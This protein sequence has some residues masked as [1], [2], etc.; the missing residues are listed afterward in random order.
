MLAGLVA[1]A[2]ARADSPAPSGDDQR[3]T[4]ALA[5]CASGDFAKGISILGELYAE[6]RN[7]AYVFNQGRCYQKS[8]QLEKA[9]SSF[10]E[11]LRLST[12]EPPEDVNRARAFV[13]EIDDA[14]ARERANEPAPV[15]IAPAPSGADRSRS[16]R[17]ASIVL[18]GVGV[19]AV[20][21]GAY[22][23]LKVKQTNDAINNEFAGMDYVTDPA[24]L[25]RQLADG[26]RYET[27]QWVGYGLGIAA[28]AGAVTTFVISGGGAATP[29]AAP[30]GAAAPA[31][32]ALVDVAPVLS[33]GGVGGF[34]R[35]RF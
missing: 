32:H 22:L 28:M 7:P 18:A 3:S 6:T 17:I 2:S 13:K 10:T 5:A 9:R 8:D 16:L 12:N 30:P 31:E 24:R 21:T 4:V 27:W 11:Y 33:P 25:E 26:Q 14:L 35:I 23:S 1:S 34:A 19:A 20:A 29:S 15:I